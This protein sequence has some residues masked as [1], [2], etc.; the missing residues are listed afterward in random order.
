MTTT[1]R[2]LILA[3]DNDLIGANAILLPGV[4]IGVGALIGAGSVVTKDVVAGAVVVDN[5]ARV[6]NYVKNIEDYQ[7]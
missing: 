2:L 1:P 6:I 7:I 4:R 3:S 5:P